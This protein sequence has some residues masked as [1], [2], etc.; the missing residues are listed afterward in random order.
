MLYTGPRGNSTEWQEYLAENSGIAE[1]A[2]IWT[3]TGVAFIFASARWYVRGWVKQKLWSDDY[4]IAVSIATGIIA[5]ALTTVSALKGIGRHVE[6]LSNEQRI[7]AT[8][9]V[10]AA[11]CPSVLSF[12]MPKLAVIALLARLLL[13]SRLHLCMLWT[14]GG[15]VQ[16]AL[17][18][19]VGL[20]FGR[21][22]P[23]LSAVDQSIP[24]HCL[25]T[26]IWVHYCLFAASFSAFVDF[27]LDAY[28]SL[29]L[30]KLQMARRKKI[31]L[32]IALGLGAILITFNSS[33][34]VAIYKTI[35]LLA[36][37]DPDFT[38]RASDATSRITIWTLI[39]GNTIVIASSIPVLQPLMNMASDK[40]PARR[41]RTTSRWK[42][43]A[44]LFSVKGKLATAVQRRIREHEELSDSSPRELD[45]V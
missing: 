43:Y 27:Y 20:L 13:P 1:L 15:L 11:Y 23:F 25:D 26:D 30:Y 37:S 32:S 34:A 29:V 21:C 16:F 36:L 39:E 33:G 31:V 4:L 3:F 28:P 22:Q 6:A 9:W 2:V 8:L 7:S 14:M 35:V 38:F 5:C 42:Y 45:S 24:G 41:Q 10:Y 17:L 12:G 19:V 18:G 40:S 44:A